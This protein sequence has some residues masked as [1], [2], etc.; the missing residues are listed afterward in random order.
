MLFKRII[1]CD[2][3]VQED[4]PVPGVHLLAGLLP[5]RGGGGGVDLHTPTAGLGPEGWPIQEMI[6]IFDQLKLS[7]IFQ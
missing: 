4:H 6:K 3:A 5:G 2:C 7:A 1:L